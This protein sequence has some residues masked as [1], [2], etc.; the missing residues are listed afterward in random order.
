MAD[1]VEIAFPSEAKA[2]QVRQNLL[3]M[4]KE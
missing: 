1:P 3:D 4:Q 2:E